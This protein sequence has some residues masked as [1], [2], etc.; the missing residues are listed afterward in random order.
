MAILERLLTSIS[1]SHGERT[2]RTEWS[3]RSGNLVSTHRLGVAP[4]R[5][6]VFTSIAGVEFDE[7]E[8]RAVATTLGEVPVRVIGLADLK[9]NKRAAG[10][11]QDLADLEHL[12]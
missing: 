9:T 2:P 12:P 10:R 8:S 3:R 1:G 5:I 4:V 7:C 6:E 11:H